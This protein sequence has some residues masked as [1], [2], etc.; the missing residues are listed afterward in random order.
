MAEK[1]TKFVSGLLVK[2]LKRID[3]LEAACREAIECLTPDRDWSSGT[4]ITEARKTLKAVL[5]GEE[6]GDNA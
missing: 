1:A 3:E 5:D 4:M 2:Y 6:R